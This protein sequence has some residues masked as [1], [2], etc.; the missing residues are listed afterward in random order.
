MA[1]A[2]TLY[3]KAAANFKSA[4]LLLDNANGDEEQLNLAGYHLQQALELTLKYL[5]EQDGIEYPKT[6]DIDQLIRIG[7]ES[8]VDL[9]LSEY[10]IDHAEMFSLWEA[11]ARYILGYAIEARKLERALSEI[12]DYLAAVADAESSNSN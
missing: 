7:N 9:Q 4:K 5:L 10:L 12:D 11:K 3:G 1:S 8:R 2:T 6:H